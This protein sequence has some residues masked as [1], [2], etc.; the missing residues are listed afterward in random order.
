VKPSEAGTVVRVGSPL[1]A[2]WQRLSSLLLLLTAVALLLLG[3]IDAM[4]VEGVRTAVN[5]AIAPILGAISRPVATVTRTVEEMAELTSLQE[6]NGKLKAENAKLRL[7]YD[8]ALKLEAE[9]KSLRE[10]LNFV[11]EP[12]SAY[13]TARVVADTGGVFARSVLIT[14]GRKDGIAKNQ[15]AIAG[16]GLVGRVTEVGN[17]SGRILLITDLNSRIPVA[18]ENSRHRGVLAGDNSDQP[19]L[20]HLPPE[21]SIAIGER[22]VTSGHGGVFPIG[23]PIGVVASVQ[24][25]VIRVQP[26]VDLGRLEH[27]RVVDYSRQVLLEKG[28]LSESEP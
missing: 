10:L 17:R 27:I 28:K 25:G 13:R 19:R 14:A 4:L 22:V 9:N 5:D 16:Q 2:F 6:E 11:V 7:W 8:A 21:V 23:L 1:R 3:K 20:V 18:L 24:Q 12:G 26:L 15:A